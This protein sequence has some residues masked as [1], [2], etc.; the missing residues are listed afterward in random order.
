MN[1]TNR[2][3]PRS[4]N[5]KRHPKSSKPLKPQIS[6]LKVGFL[7]FLFIAFI[8]FLG[9]RVLEIKR[10]YGN[11]FE[12]RAIRQLTSQGALSEQEIA[13]N[14]GMI[15]DRNRELILA[16]SYMT[17]DVFL[18]IRVLVTLRAETRAASLK[19]VNEI[20]GIPMETLEEY[21]KTENVYDEDGEVVRVKP[22]DEYDSRHYVIEK[23]ISKELA[24]RLEEANARCV[25]LEGKSK[26]TYPEGRLAAQAVG[27][28]RGDSS[29]GIEQRYNLFLT[30]TPGKIYRQFTENDTIVPRRDEAMDGYT[31]VTAIDGRMQKY[32]EE[33]CKKYYET[34]E[35]KK[36]SVLVMNPNTGE[37]LTMAAYPAFDLNIP[38]DPSGFS[39]PAMSDDWD[40][41]SETEQFNRLFSLWGNYNIASTIEPGSIFKPFVVA[42]A[43]EEGVITT[44][45]RFY[46]QGYKTVD[47]RPI[48][49]NK[50]SGHGSISL[51]EA[52]AQSCNV[53]HMDIAELMGPEIF[54]KY[55]MDFGFGQKT[56]IDLPGEESAYSLTH[57]LENIRA[58]ELATGSFGQRFN[59]TP[60]QAISGFCSLINGGNLLKPYVVSRVLDS[61]NNLIFENAP[62]TERKTISKKTSDY[63]RTALI[64]VMLPTGTGRRAAIEGYSIGAKTGTGEQ[65]IKGTPDYH[66][67]ISMVGYLPAESPEYV[68]IVIIDW[69]KEFVEGV[70]SPAT[71]FQ[72][73]MRFIIEYKG[74]PSENE[75]SELADL[76]DRLDVVI[77]PDLVGKY[78]PEATAV[79]NSL[80]LD[81][82]FIGAAGTTV[83][84]QYPQAGSR[85]S[86]SESILLTI[87]GA[88]ND[89]L[90]KTPYVEGMKAADAVLIIE[91]SGLTP[92]VFY[93]DFPIPDEEPGDDTYIIYAQMPARETMVPPGTEVKIKARAGD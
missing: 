77:M 4:N 81:Y 54:Y 51:D 32:A 85:V 56:G 15:V 63:I 48:N 57:R 47:G 33:I 26:R 73:I 18:D 88:G 83:S 16:S 35:A 22:L 91:A 7:G 2:G 44:D 43:L 87:T 9:Y 41:L 58:S 84:N 11:D 14:R 67:A 28:I 13:P 42:A 53:A 20:L 38:T 86:K 12:Q 8:I 10:I 52:L 27:F 55:Q 64:D 59:C 3:R 34:Y 39:D 50:R 75:R 89:S 49:C 21:L 66:Y 45:S 17:Y 6:K 68:A 70:T 24:Q 78:I 29:W 79:L 40:S 82:E 30:G 60:I 76:I 36:T 62:I 65:G 61:G 93:D 23:E 5:I 92:K 37:V 25:Y 74:I 69:P 90:I 19:T 80:S 71:M 72:D 46:C 1:D 31:V